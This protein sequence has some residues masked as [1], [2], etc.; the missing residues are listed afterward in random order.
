MSKHVKHENFPSTVLGELQIYEVEII[1]FFST[2]ILAWWHE[3]PE[4]ARI[5]FHER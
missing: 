3:L 5:L 2:W 1:K 4:V